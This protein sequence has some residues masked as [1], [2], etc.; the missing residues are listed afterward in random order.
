[1][2]RQLKRANEKSDKRREQEQARRKKARRDRVQVVRARAKE[3]AK[4][5]AKPAQRSAERPGISR[6]R[7][8]F[9]N[10]Y[11]IFVIF[12]IITQAFFPQRTDTFALVTHALFYGILG[13][14]LTLWLYRR[15]TA[16]APFYTAAFGVLLALGV[17]GLKFLLPGL[18]PTDG[19]GSTDP[20]LIFPL[21]AVP[22]VLLGAG[23]GYL[24]YR[25]NPDA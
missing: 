3:G 25:R 7:R 15:G 8:R 5:G 24:V 21:L 16:P 2:N 11:L 6:L 14:F 22:G 19:V 18:E 1:M 23:L 20:N 10:W 13:Y 12:F 4:E 17:E 9:A